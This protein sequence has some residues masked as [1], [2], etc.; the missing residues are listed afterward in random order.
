MKLLITAVAGAL[1][2]PVSLWSQ[3]TAQSGPTFSKDVMPIIQEHCQ[4]CHRPGEVA[5]M[6]LMSYEEVRPWAQSIRNKVLNR[7]MPPW[8]ADPKHGEFA[9]DRRLS[10]AEIKTIVN[11]IDAGAPRGNPADLPPAK[12][13]VDGWNI[14]QPDVVLTM[15]VEQKI[16]PSGTDEYLYFALPTNFSED[17]YV[18]AIEIRP[19]NR[20]IVHHVVAYVQKG[21]AGVPTRASADS[22]NQRAG[23]N[24]FRSEGNAL[25]VNDSA[26]VYDD[27]CSLPNGGSALSGDV[28]GGGRPIIAG[29]VPG[30]QTVIMPDGLARKI[31][32]GSEILFQIHYTKT[33]KDE[34]DRTSIGFV[35]AKQPPRTLLLDRWVQNFYFKI[36]ANAANY[37]AKGCYTFDQDVDVLSFGPHMHVRGKDMEYKAFY[38][39][40]RS[41]ILLNV[42]NYDFNWQLWYDLKSPLHIP[43]GTRIEVTAHYDNSAAKRSNPN[44]GVAVRWGDPTSDEMMIGAMHYVLSS[45][46]PK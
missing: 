3:N 2:I 46:K 40:G 32:A 7:V 25:R 28:T 36:P 23:A 31:P 35:F 12:K 16:G 4:T 5:P 18:Q 21:G 1:L 8:F 34:T 30:S 10:D 6:S 15:A 45:E 27:G 22:Y 26:P 14:G 37:E 43:R 41:E 17:R 9:N 33:G 39:D 13:F 42:P 11:W 20:R 19:G 29:Y 38:P 44:P 24:F